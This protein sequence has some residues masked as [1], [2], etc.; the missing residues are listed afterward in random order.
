MLDYIQNYFFA[1]ELVTLAIV[2]FFILLSNF[3]V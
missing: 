1:L 3:G 2:I